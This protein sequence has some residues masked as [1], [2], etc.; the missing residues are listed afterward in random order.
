MKTIELIKSLERFNKPFYSI[1]DIEKIT[2]L[3][4]KS[5]Y[6]AVKRLVDRGIL[7]RVGKGIYRPFTVKLSIERIAASLYTPNYLSFEFAL[8]RYGVFNLVPYTLTFATTRKTKR[9]TVEGR[10]IEFRRIKKDLFWGYEIQ[11]G[12]Y[13]A[14]PEK[15]FLDLVYLASR[16]IASLDLDELDIKK[17]SMSRVKEFSKRFPRYT[18]KYL[19]KLISS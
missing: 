10:D 11:G 2:G 12:I 5:L 8:S 15:A 14:K 13:V 17:L 7:E 3:S 19:Y 6:V 1:A 18:Q 4:R 16:G 9:L